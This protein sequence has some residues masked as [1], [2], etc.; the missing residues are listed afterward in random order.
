MVKFICKRLGYMLLTIFVIITIT[1]MLT[2]AIPGDPLGEAAEKMAPEAR[3]NFMAKYNLDKTVFQQYTIYIT[4]VFTK[5][6][7]GDSMIFPGRSI[8]DIIKQTIPVSA[9]VG[10]QSL[11][12]GV[13]VGLILGIIA[14]FNRSKAPDYIVMT[15]ALVFVSVPSFVFAALLQYLF[16]G[17]KWNLLPTTGWG[18]Y[19]HTILPALA[20]CFGYVASYARYMRASCLDV[21]GQ[22]YIQTAKAKGV[23]KG[24]LIWK[25]II[26]NA[27]LP[28][29]TM[30]GLSVA[31]VVTGSFVIETI[32]GVPGTGQ[33]FVQ[34]VSNRDYTMIMGMVIFT[35][36]LYIVA[37]IVIDILYTLIDPRIK[38][39]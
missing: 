28:I 35:S 14:A 23:S 7:L 37:L 30:L 38:L 32:F 25:H 36:I 2:H 20:G 39:D 4:N 19:K 12:F 13:I 31:F 29:I 3:A 5:G 21:I 9:A 8:N 17:G 26:R 6:D 33:Y 24:A 34:S 11:A 16:A 27:I 22:D 10:I 1:F 18:E 15:L